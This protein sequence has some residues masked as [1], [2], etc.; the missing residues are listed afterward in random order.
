MKK[1][2]LASVLISAGMA[3]VANVSY[4]VGKIIG[5]AEAAMSMMEGVKEALHTRNTR[6]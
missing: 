2:L 5:C 1:T 6:M 4:H 3:V